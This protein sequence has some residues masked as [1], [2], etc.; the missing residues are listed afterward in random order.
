VRTGK[1]IYLEAGAD[2][3][4]DSRSHLP[5][6]LTLVALTQQVPHLDIYTT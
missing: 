1:A 6:D 3:K 5:A 2:E 4:S